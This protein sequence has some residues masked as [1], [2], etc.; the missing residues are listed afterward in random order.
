MTAS[1]TALATAE[2]I[3]I[4]TSVFIPDEYVIS[5]TDPVVPLAHI[6][7]VFAAKHNIT[8]VSK[9]LKEYFGTFA[10]VPLSKLFIN[11]GEQRF[12]EDKHIL[13]INKNYDHDLC[14]PLIAVYY[15]ETDTYRVVDGQQHA[16][17]TLLQHIDFD[18]EEVELPVWFVLGDESTERKLVLGLN[19]D[20]LPMARFFIHQAE[21]KNNEPTAV[22]IQ[23][24]CNRV[25]VVPAYK[26]KG[27]LPCITHITN[28]YISYK[29]LGEKNTAKAL[30]VLTTMFPTKANG[31]SVQHINTLAVL[32]LAGVF[33][34]LKA[35]KVYTDE[36]AED[37]GLAMQIA[38]QD[39]NAVHKDIKF[40]FE[41]LP[42]SQKLEVENI[43]R[44][45][46]GILKTYEVITGQRVVDPIYDSVK[47]VV[48]LARAQ[49]VYK[50]MGGLY[51]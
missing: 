8:P 15:P 38:F 16:I 41:Q 12:P 14:T 45:S 22:K 48:A 26:A 7:R 51:A 46:S 17:A 28:L 42:K 10:W 27:K 19:R 31:V 9:A 21:V 25:G 3:E 2:E 24:M 5:P 43:G 33:K 49:R 1:A 11:F 35:E 23:N 39:M 37:I 6:S 18:D 34:Q 13:K 30:E 50:Q 47:P 40:W 4:D 36:L 32:G 29:S 44:Y 20:N